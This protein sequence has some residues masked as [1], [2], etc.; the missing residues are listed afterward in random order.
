MS[1]FTA[2][3]I[4]YL[5]GQRLGRMAT[6]GPNGRPHVAPVGFRLDAEA[7]AIEIGGHNLAT[8]KKWRDLKASASIAFVVD[9]LERVDP[10]TPRGIEIRGHAE[11]FEQGGERLGPGFGA[12]WI[13]VVPERIIAWGIDA[14][15]FSGPP[16]AR[17]VA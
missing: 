9:D 12:S 17:T 10:W 14:P 3:E 15:T 7:Q 16:N 11:L 6:V 8:S 1:V 5:Q 2:G 13:R 4:E